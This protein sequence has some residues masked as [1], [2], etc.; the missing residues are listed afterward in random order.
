LLDEKIVLE[1]TRIA[2]SETASGAVEGSLGRTQTTMGT[3]FVSDT[4]LLLRQRLLIV[5]LIWAALTGVRYLFG[6]FDPYTGEGLASGSLLARTLFSFAIAGLLA[7]RRPLHL[8]Q[9]RLI[10]YLYFGLLTISILVSQ[11]LVSSEL[12]TRGDEISLVS[13][14]KNGVIR[15]LLLML[16]YGTMIPNNAKRATRVILSMALCPVLVL[17]SLRVA[18]SGSATLFADHKR[19]SQI[20]ISNGLFCVLGAGVAIAAAYVCRL[21]DEFSSKGSS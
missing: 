20:A 4:E 7:G 21:R 16:L 2:D 17:A 1:P 19:V 8:R 15:I 10:E 12:I 13:F 3:S 9:L 6:L 11:Y 5:A 14:D 18:Y